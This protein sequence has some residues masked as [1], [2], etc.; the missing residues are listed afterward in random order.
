MAYGVRM[1]KAGNPIVGS[2]YSILTT[3]PNGAWAFSLGWMD[4][5]MFK[6][7]ANG[8]SLMYYHQVVGYQGDDQVRGVDTADGGGV[9]MAGMYNGGTRFGMM[10]PYNCA[11]GTSDAFAACYTNNSGARVAAEEDMV[12]ALPG[13]AGTP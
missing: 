12:Q 8:N 2:S 6:M 10:G 5:M 7:S 9:H 11:G 1:D 13:Q 4:G 3:L